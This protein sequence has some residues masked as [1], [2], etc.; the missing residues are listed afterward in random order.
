MFSQLL[1]IGVHLDNLGPGLQQM[2]NH[3]KSWKSW[4]NTAISL[5][6]IKKSWKSWENTAISI[7]FVKKNWKSWGKQWFWQF[8]YKIVVFSQLLVIGGHLDSLGPGSNETWLVWGSAFVEFQTLGIVQYQAS[9]C[10]LMTHQAVTRHN[11]CD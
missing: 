1:V 8:Y 6:F 9:N 4:E 2:E 3:S 7:I 5:I 11:Q 10:F